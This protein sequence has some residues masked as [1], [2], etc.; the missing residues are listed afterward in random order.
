[1]SEL[2][3][4]AGILTY[5]MFVTGRSDYFWATYS[6]FHDAEPH[7]LVVCTTGS[8]DGTQDVVSDLGG[9]DDAGPASVGR[10]M[11][12]AIEACIASGADIIVF[13]ADDVVPVDGWLPRLVDFWQHAPESVKLATLFLEGQFDWNRI[14]AAA[15]VGRE[16]VLFRA[17]IPGSS[18]SFRAADWPLIGPIEQR[19]GGEDL[20]ICQRLR[21]HNYSLAALDL[22]VHAGREQSAWGNESHRYE[23]PLNR[24]AYG[25][26]AT[27]GGTA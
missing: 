23:M 2:T 14:A 5:Q 25:F 13:S 7:A 9:I 11:T 3:V 21:H 1:M 26:P 16:R 27:I 12:L 15:N 6:A 24:H 4:A 10:G 19:T 22:A 18:W 17:S 8:S 20:A